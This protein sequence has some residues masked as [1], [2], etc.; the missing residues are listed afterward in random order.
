M[1][2]K[3]QLPSDID[4]IVLFDNN[5]DTGEACF[6]RCEPP[7]RHRSI[8]GRT[9]RFS[10]SSKRVFHSGNSSETR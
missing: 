6:E 9:S 3:N 8:H 10:T 2:T 4:Y 5:T 7:F 1:N